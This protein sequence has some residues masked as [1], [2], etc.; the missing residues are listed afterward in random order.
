MASGDTRSQARVGIAARTSQPYSSCMFRLFR[1]RLIQWMRAMTLSFSLAMLAFSVSGMEAGHAMGPALDAKVVA[2]SVAAAQAPCDQCG[3]SDHE[4]SLAA[5]SALCASPM[6]IL[7]HPALPPIGAKL[8]MTAAPLI[9]PLTSHS[10]PP[11][12]YPPKPAVL[13]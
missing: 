5:C 7:P 6:A 13:S 12:P 4:M 9:R 10:D 1:S 11:D 3:G 2:A 8:R